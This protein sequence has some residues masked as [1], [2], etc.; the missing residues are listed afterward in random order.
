MREEVF[1]G[2]LRVR[3]P[4]SEPATL[5]VT[6]QGLGRATK[7]WVTFDGG[8]ASTAVLDRQETAQLADLL[9]AAAAA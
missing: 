8:W 2:T 5:I 1:R 3:N 7:V 6:R 4:D 9:M